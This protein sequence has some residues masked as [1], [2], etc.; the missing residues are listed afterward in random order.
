MS[1]QRIL[2]IVFLVLGVVLLIIGVNASDSIADQLS[3][4]FTGK[5]TDRTTWYILGG[6]GLAVL[7]AIVAFLPGGKLAKH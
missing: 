5:F 7:G 6:I 1:M 4:T 2:G 3:D